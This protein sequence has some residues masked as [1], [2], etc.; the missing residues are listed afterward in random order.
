LPAPI[1]I[2]AELTGARHRA[3]GFG[4]DRHDL[5]RCAVN[6]DQ[7]HACFRPT[8]QI[9]TSYWDE[10]CKHLAKRDRVMKK[11]IP[12]FGEARLQGAR[13]RFCDAGPVSIIGQQITVKAA[14]SVW[15]KLALP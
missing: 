6:N 2:R 8:V 7:P 5:G 9:Y 11:L 3:E 1:A 15:N 10:A 13:R 12:Q 4:A 14:Q